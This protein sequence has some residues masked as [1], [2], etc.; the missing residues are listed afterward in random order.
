[1]LSK[2]NSV[3]IFGLHTFPVE[4]EVFVTGGKYRFDIVGLPD[5][6][7]S[8]AKE[9]VRAAVKNS[10]LA[11]SD[12]RITVN[13]A[14]ADV[15]KEGSL[16][17]LPIFMAIVYSL[18]RNAPAINDC[19]FI[20][21][22]SLAGEVRSVN[23]VLPM[24]LEARSTGIKRMFVPYANVAEASVVDGIDV[25]G[26]RHVKQLL[27][28]FEDKDMTEW[29]ELVPVEKLEYIPAT[30]EETMLDFSDVKGQQAAKRAL[31]VAAAGGHNFL[32]VGSPG[33]G[34]SM[35]AKRIPGIL[36]D[37]TFEESLE[38]TKIYSIAGL[39]KRGEGLVRSR[40][41]RSPHHTV[42]SAG[43]SG[44]GAVPRPG[45]VSLA[46]NG[47]LFLDEMPEFSRSAMEV[48]R[49]PIEDGRITIS[50]AAG[51]LTY[52][53]SVM[54][55]AAMNPCPCGYL[56]HPTRKCTCSKQ[57]AE[58]YVS[59][60]SGP[61]LDRIDIQVEVPPVNFDEL[62]E[63]SSAEETSA[64]IKKRVDKARRVQAERFKGTST[65]CNAKM[66]PAQTREFCVMTDRAKALL[67]GAFER[68]GLSARA[69][70]KILRVA[71][72]IADLD[73]SDIIDINHTTEAIKYRSY[74]RKRLFPEG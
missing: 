2:V 6:A 15:K 17:D 31:E 57:A 11:F 73:G 9:R 66:T 21:E 74:D 10:G 53:C 29:G 39:L 56:G 69:Y 13:L 33:S 3:G 60:V 61:L 42:S 35:L 63:K 8:E 72:T 32:M 1:M 36:P 45:E 46:H 25:Y 68:L 55:V 24:V 14:P 43:L 54:L 22:L 50:R 12:N 7:V 28:Y 67:K 51:T 23:G 64:D 49:Q 44:G 30:A 52:P 20:G 65:T 40:P 5:A 47:V 62:T 59:R 37:M 58:K 41:F 71:R 4:A 16:Y 26:V 48:M 70:D 18:K 34:K 38:T 27:A 19:A